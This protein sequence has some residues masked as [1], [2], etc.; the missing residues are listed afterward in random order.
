MEGW[1][2]SLTLHNCIRV[3]ACGHYSQEGGDLKIPQKCL[4]KFVEGLLMAPILLPTLILNKIAGC[5]QFSGPGNQN[6]LLRK[7]TVD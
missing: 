1:G 6:C 7:S 2:L 4:M 5:Q 3:S